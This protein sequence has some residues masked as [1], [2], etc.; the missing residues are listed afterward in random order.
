MGLNIT[1]KI[2]TAQSSAGAAATGATAK[3]G[4]GVPSSAQF[5]GAVAAKAPSF[6]SAAVLDNE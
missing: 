2:Q 4:T 3:G 1:K 5:C 6:Q